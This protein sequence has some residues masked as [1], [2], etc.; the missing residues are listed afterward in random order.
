MMIVDSKYMTEQYEKDIYNY[1]KKK[2]ITDIHSIAD[3]L[4]LE[5][6]IV[7]KHVNDLQKK[8]YLMIS[9]VLPLINQD[10]KNSPYYSCTSKVY[11]D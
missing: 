4:K 10:I 2:G 7:L 5:E 3:K 8:G 11:N 9:A 1:V 6:I